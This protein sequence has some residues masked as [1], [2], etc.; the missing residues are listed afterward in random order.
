MAPL[1]VLALGNAY[2]PLHLGGYELIWRGVDRYLVECGHAV[3]VVTT[4]WRSES[5]TPAMVAQDGGVDIHRELDWYWHAHCW[6]DL[7]WRARLALERHNAAVFARHLAEFLPDVL[8]WWPVGGLSLSLLE[9]SRR[10]GVPSVLFMLDPWLDYGPRHDLWLRGWERLRPLAGVAARV[11]GLPTRVQYDGLGR[12]VFCSESLRAATLAA[13]PSLGETAV[14]TPGLDHAWLTLP[15][16]QERPP[17]RGRLLYAG[18]VVEQKGVHTAIR[19]LVHLPPDMDLTV[20]G[21]GDGAYRARLEALVTELRLEG[22]VTFHPAVSPDAL[23]ERYRAADA[24]LFP[25]EWE[26]PFGLVPL[27]A[28]AAG[29]PVIATG[30]GGSGDYLRSEENALLFPAGD[31]SALAA[32][33]ERLARDP[34]LRE[35]LQTGGRR[36]AQAHSETNFDAA[37]LAQ[38]Q[39]AADGAN[40]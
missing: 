15:E 3:R 19:A 14:L 28:M 27:E 30:R 17:W 39:R 33:V 20:L 9:Q 37:A 11:T 29:R 7:G 10:A 1:R 5:A 6:R 22:R 16:E 32:A 31:A 24:V 21:D 23:A 8:A 4:T 36:T 25:V 18:R 35:Q 13:H 26:E 2:P 40:A 12:W 38:L 34:T